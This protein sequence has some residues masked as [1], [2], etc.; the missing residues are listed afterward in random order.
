MALRAERGVT[1]TIVAVL[2]TVVLAALATQGL[3]YAL[4]A[5]VLAAYFAF[6]IIFGAR[7]TGIACMMA[8][9]ATAPM[10]RGIE[11]AVGGLPPTDVFLIIGTIHLLP[12]F[13]QHRLRLPTIY[14]LGLLLVSISSLIA[15][16]ITGDLLINAFYA[17]QWLFFIGALPI[18]IA[19]WRPGLPIINRLLWSYLAGHVISTGWAMAEG[20]AYAGRY[21]GL[22]HH[23]NAFGLGGVTSIAIVLF[24]FRVY[25]D[26]RVRVILAGFVA[27]SVLSITLSGS[28]A[29]IVVLVALILLI[30]IV[31]RSA[32]AGIGLA[33]IGALGVMA[34]PFV[35]DVSGEESAIGRLAGSGTAT[36]SDRVRTK[37]LE[38]GFDRF[39]ESPILGSGFA[40]VEELHNVFLEAAVA[41]GFIG[42]LAY[43][44]VLFALA[45]PLFST[46]PLRRLTYLVW[47]YMGVAPTFPGLW[48]RTVWVPASLAALAMLAPEMR[49][50]PADRV[51][52]PARAPSPP[53]S[54]GRA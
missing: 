3:I 19:W 43:L 21:D 15:V 20:A 36:A 6:A 29:A 17:V 41:I 45:R 11:Q 47:V 8:A 14:L 5:L 7:G 33:A 34:I 22:T 28:R 37:G 32:L 38:A 53:V 18:I 48:D 39:W 31:E 10:Y 44:V 4:A 40:G 25:T 42:L 9:F 2:F 1:V 35:V 16:V 51:V 54:P 13:M 49:H 52:E 46:H 27:V 50:A 26:V 12:T 30:P 23:P 24:L